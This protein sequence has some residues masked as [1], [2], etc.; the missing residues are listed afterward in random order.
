[1]SNA[2]QLAENQLANASLNATEKAAIAIKMLILT[3]DY[4]AVGMIHVNP[5]SK[6]HRR[7]SEL[8]NNKERRFLAITDVWLTSR[9]GASSP[10]LYPFLQIHLD[11]IVLIHPASQSIVSTCSNY[12]INDA[13]RFNELREKVQPD[14][15]RYNF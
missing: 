8:L 15:T 11:S 10:R 6:P 13:S 1:M 5:R 7:I 2:P 3:T 9:H 4:E 12:T 14:D